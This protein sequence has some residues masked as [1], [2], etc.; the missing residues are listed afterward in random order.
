MKRADRILPLRPTRRPASCHFSSGPTRK[1]PGWSPDVLSDAFLGRSHRGRGGKAK[2]QHALNLMRALLRLPDDYLIGIVPASD[3]G[4]MEMALWSLLGVRGVDILVWDAFGKTWASDVVGQLKLDD[5]RVFTAPYGALPDFSKLSDDR[6]VVLTWN[7]T[8]AGV[9][10]PDDSW[11]SCRREGLII[12]DATSAVFAMPMPVDK[13]DVMTFSWQKSLGGEAAHGV[14]VLSPKAVDRL[15]S[16]IP[17]WP[18][19][20]IF[21]LAEDGKLIA[22]IFHGETINTP[23]ML[24]VEDAIDALSWAQSVGGVDG[25]IKR[26]DANFAVIKT[27]VDG[28]SEFA[29]LAQDPASISPTSMTLIITAEWFTKSSEDEQARIVKML[30][31]MLEDEGVAFDIAAYRDAPRGLRIWGGP[32]V[33]AD[34]LLILTEWI[35]W[36]MSQINLSIKQG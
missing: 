13:L 9:R 32:T 34:D 20:K 7:G 23:S 17:S 5:V 30:V 27:W 28:H 3:T 24:C 2:L 35:D 16:T 1:R 11:M 10:V 36:G 25:L 6:D 19:P 29:F 15:Q 18:M 22:G 31:E 21:R 14:I 26:V 8:S 12:V 33:D 4:A